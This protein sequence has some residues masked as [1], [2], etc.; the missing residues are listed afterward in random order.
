MGYIPHAILCWRVK[1]ALL[2]CIVAVLLPCISVALCLSGLEGVKQWFNDRS[3]CSCEFTDRSLNLP[4]EPYFKV[5]TISGRSGNFMFK[6]E[7]SG[8]KGFLK[9]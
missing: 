7:K 6:L 8:K 5:A 9:I 3:W 4:T 1:N 2:Q